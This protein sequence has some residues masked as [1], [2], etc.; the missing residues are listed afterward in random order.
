M[1]VSIL[2]S[3]LFIGCLSQ[4]SIEEDYKNETQRDSISSKLYAKLIIRV[5]K[6]KVALSNNKE[7]NIIANSQID[8][9]QFQVI[10]YQKDIIHLR[11]IELDLARFELNN[12]DL[13]DK[14]SILNKEASDLKD[15][16]KS[17][18]IR[19]SNERNKSTNLYEQNNKLKKQFKLSVAG[20]VIKSYGYSK[21]FLR[22][23]KEIETSKAKDVKFININFII[24]KNSNIPTA[25]YVLHVTLY[26]V[27]S[28][29]SV[30]RDFIVHFD[31]EEKSCKMVFND[32]SD[33]QVGY[34]KIDIRLENEL[35]FNGSINLE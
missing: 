8:S 22:K 26:G 4:P 6:L 32:E 16:N 21:G 29:K 7:E 5:A 11:G 14:I 33:F 35:L 30:S 9:L 1:R 20:V 10:K 27:S 13:I 2:L 31:G 17:I 28:I 23:S 24:P 12:K 19:L 34:H 15:S 25:T 18:N 3:V